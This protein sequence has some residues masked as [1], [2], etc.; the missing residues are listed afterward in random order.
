M[1]LNNLFV[2]MP[3]E[4]MIIDTKIHPTNY[5]HNSNQA[6]YIITSNEQNKSNELAHLILVL[7]AVSRNGACVIV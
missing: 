3:N 4:R 6:K 5:L 7:I 2:S 1:Y